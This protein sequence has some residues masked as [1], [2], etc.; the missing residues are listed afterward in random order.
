MGMV[1]EH[2]AMTIRL[3]STLSTEYI[4]AWEALED[5]GIEVWHNGDHVN[6]F[7]KVGE[8]QGRENGLKAAF[9]AALAYAMKTE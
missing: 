3:Y 1:S 7:W 9:A 6:Y 2:V 4:H 8:N 5:A